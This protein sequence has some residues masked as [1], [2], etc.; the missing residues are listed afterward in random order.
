MSHNA[1]AKSAA[2]IAMMNVAV[3]GIKVGSMIPLEMVLTPSPPART[4]PAVPHTAAMTS[5]PP[6]VRAREPTAGPTLLATSLA[7][8]LIAM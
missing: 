6:M 3:S 8:M 7:P 1:A 4:A 5:A 2:V